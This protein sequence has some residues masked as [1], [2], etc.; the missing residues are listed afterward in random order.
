MKGLFRKCSLFALLFVLLLTSLF[1]LFSNDVHAVGEYTR[2]GW[3]ITITPTFTSGTSYS[4]AINITAP[5]GKYANIYYK[6]YTDSTTYQNNSTTGLSTHT[7]NA[8][9]PYTGSRTINMSG[10]THIR[11]YA[12]DTSQDV[13]AQGFDLITTAIDP[14]YTPPTNYDSLVSTTSDLDI[15]SETSV[16]SA[17]TILS[18]ENRWAGDVTDILED[19]IAHNGLSSAYLDAWNDK[20]DWVVLHNTQSGDAKT[21]SVYWTK[22]TT[23]SGSFV[24]ESSVKK[25]KYTK[26]GTEPIYYLNIAT[27]SLL[28]GSGCDTTPSYYGNGTTLTIEFLESTN[29]TTKFFIA[30]PPVTYP[31]DYE[32][33]EVPSYYS[34]FNG[35]LSYEI[36]DKIGK[37]WLGDIPTGSKSCTL[38]VD[39]NKAIPPDDAINEDIYDWPSC[40]STKK[41]VHT[42]SVYGTYYVRLEVVLADNTIRQFTHTFN[43]DGSTYKGV[44][45]KDGE[46]TEDDS[47]SPDYED[48]S[49][50]GADIIQGISCAFRNFGKFLQWLVTYLI[51]PDKDELIALVNELI[52]AI[53]TSLGFL[54]YPV[55]FFIDLVTSMATATNTCSPAITSINGES[56]GGHL[57]GSNV[58]LDVCSLEDSIPKAYNVTV[59]FIRVVTVL[60]LMY[61]LYRR[62]IELLTIRGQI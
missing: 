8:A 38:Y 52:D 44:I 22:N 33:L 47:I 23:L 49:I 2:S 51:I 19:R 56:I 36:V 13:T 12:F 30:T 16:C 54:F 26:T 6:R 17:G 27:K 3:G 34:A 55:Q 45:D 50:Y 24:T 37:F 29:T 15:R 5:S 41:V 11:F 4:F 59:F 40:E 57:F 32:G 58:N 1:T 25:L 60:A 35:T 43:V 20:E 48:C 42:W 10:Y 18:L 21:I 39:V 62:W 9:T 53:S 28:T 31:V 46:A 14:T 61:A 7:T